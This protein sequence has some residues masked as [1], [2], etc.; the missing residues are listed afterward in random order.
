MKIKL[1]PPRP[2]KPLPEHVHAVTSKGREYFYFQMGRSTP[3]A[4]PRIKLVNPWNYEEISNAHR[5]SGL[6]Y[7]GGSPTDWK[8]E[9][10]RVF[11]SARIR[12]RTQAMEFGIDRRSLTDIL[13]E[14][15]Y[16]CAISRLYFDHTGYESCHA[17]PFAMSIDRV[18]TRLGYTSRNVRLVCLIVNVALGQWGLPAVERMA[19]AVASESRRKL[20]SEP[21]VAIL[22]NGSIS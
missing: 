11:T 16:R 6:T 22:K 2:N 10:N 8:A 20:E 9:I 18:D 12:A 5:S 21:K 4:G 3:F 13:E 7:R 15:E 19:A 1:A 17:K 14:Q